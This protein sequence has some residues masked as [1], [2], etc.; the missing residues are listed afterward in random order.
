MRHDTT[1][2]AGGG[3]AEVKADAPQA[4]YNN[5]DQVCTWA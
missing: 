2:P 1:E 5:P 3:S 4:S